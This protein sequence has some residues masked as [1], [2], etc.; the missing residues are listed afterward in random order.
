[1]HLSII[2]PTLNEGASIAATLAALGGCRAR[3]HEVIVVDGGSDDDTVEVA[4]ALAD[5]VVQTRRGRAEQ[6]NCGAKV[7]R[8]EVL[9]FVHA[10]TRVPQDADQIVVQ[11]LRMT[12][13]H[14]G[15]FDVALSGGA[16][17]FRLIEVMINAR[18]RLTGVSTGDQ[19]IFVKRGLFDRVGG[20]P[21]VPLM[22][23]IG[24]SR[25][26][27]KIGRP[28]C[29]KDRLVTS[30]R[31]WEEHGLMRTVVL[32]WS[33][34]LAYA[35]GVRPDVLKRFYQDQRAVGR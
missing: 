26:L 7:A 12:G 13:R 31:R 9:W 17:P 15:R 18:S 5:K 3:G 8:G 4:R 11:G 10:D 6:M 33:L 23:D 34:R 21:S 2:V 16:R 28:L 27:K 35:I 20:F 30:S 29:L 24:L 25:R 14:W 1:M 22:E 32:M 19:G